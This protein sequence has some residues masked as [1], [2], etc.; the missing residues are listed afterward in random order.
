MRWWRMWALIMSWIARGMVSD[1]EE[2]SLKGT[3]PFICGCPCCVE[4]E[5][6][7][8]LGG[9]GYMTESFG[10]PAPALLLDSPCLGLDLC[11]LGGCWL[12]PCGAVSSHIIFVSAKFIP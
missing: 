4:D 10:A 7:E 9:R 8:A 12:E 11:A 2:E 1:M 5:E 6:P 3:N